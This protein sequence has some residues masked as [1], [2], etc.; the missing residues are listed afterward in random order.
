MK[1]YIV[2]ASLA[3][4]LAFHSNARYANPSSQSA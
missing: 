4:F 2:Q 3:E 1:I